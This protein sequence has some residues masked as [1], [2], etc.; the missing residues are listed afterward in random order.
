MSKFTMKNNGSACRF[1][2]GE[3]VLLNADTSAYYSMN[4]TGAYILRE[5]LV[6]GREPNEVAQA[7]EERFASASSDLNGDVLQ[8]IA[9]LESEGLIVQADDG[10]AAPVIEGGDD[11]A[12]PNVYEKPALERHGELEQLILS[13][14]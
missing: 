12:L 8:A 4:L 2:D 1:V 13:G 6:S 10:D 3:A 14:E 9:Q 11:I 5:L 7:L